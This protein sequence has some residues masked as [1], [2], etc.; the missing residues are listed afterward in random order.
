MI[1]TTRL[2]RTVWML[3]SFGILGGTPIFADVSYSY[4]IDT[5]R[6]GAQTGALD[7]QFNPGFNSQFGFV[8]ITNFLTD[9]TLLAPV[10]TSGNV[11]GSLPGALTIANDQLFNDY[12]QPFTYGSQLSF[13]LTF[14]GPA[15]NS[16]DPTTFFSGSTFS[17]TLLDSSGFN[18]LRTSDLISGTIVTANVYNDGTTDSLPFELTPEPSFTLIPIGLLLA[19]LLAAGRRYRRRET[20]R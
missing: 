19:S 12:T 4:L 16:P 7:F 13:T 14:G 9:G 2:T 17:L 11:T 3:L 15:V 8:T 5:T 18:S 6:A 20:V 1:S 10:S